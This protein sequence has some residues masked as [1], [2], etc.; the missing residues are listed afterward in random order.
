MSIKT[1]LLRL[2]VMSGIFIGAMTHANTASAGP[3]DLCVGDNTTSS[4]CRDFSIG[5]DVARYYWFDTDVAGFDHLLRIT[6]SNVYEEFGLRFDRLFRP[7]GDDFGLPDYTCVAYGPGEQC[8]EYRTPPADTINGTPD[9]A[10]YD[11]PITWTIAWSQPIGTSPIP[12]IV[13]AEGDSL[14]FEILEN[15]IFFSAELG[16]SDFAFDNPCFPATECV[17]TEFA[18]LKTDGDPVRAALSDN[19][20]GS[21][22]VQANAPEPGTVALLGLGLSAYLA[23]VRRRRAHSR[24]VN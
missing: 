15:D 17:F 12:E 23:N 9:G 20:S 11:G 13:H 21:G 18:A 3:M 6:I 5:T 14:I 16:P 10:W 24:R 4:I 8:I 22:V 7:A 19:F 2:A 1:G